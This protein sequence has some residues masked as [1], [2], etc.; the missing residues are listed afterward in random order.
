MKR[1][2]DL[3]REILLKVEELPFDGRFYDILGDFHNQGR[4]MVRSC[5]SHYA[6]FNMRPEGGIL[7]LLS[8]PL[9]R[10]EI[11]FDQ[12]NERFRLTRSMPATKTM[13]RLLT[14]TGTLLRR[15]DTNPPSGGAAGRR[16]FTGAGCTV[17]QFSGRGIIPA[18]P[19]N[20]VRKESSRP[21]ASDASPPD[22]GMGGRLRRPVFSGVGVYD[23]G[24][25]FC[26]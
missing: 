6:T 24:C 26:K 1:D 5:N 19:S 11:S 13:P 8:E 14:G 9:S 2:M 3:V 16:H 21:S 4:V 22:Q 7:Q 23:D 25:A 20:R 15:T 10:L 12:K 18:Q 17:M